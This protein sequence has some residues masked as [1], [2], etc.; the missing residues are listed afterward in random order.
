MKTLFRPS[1]AA[2]AAAFTLSACSHTPASATPTE[3]PSRHAQHPHRSQPLFF[4]RHRIPSGK[5]HYLTRHDHL[6]RK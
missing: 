2:L 5:R 3:S 6:C 1:L 4:Q